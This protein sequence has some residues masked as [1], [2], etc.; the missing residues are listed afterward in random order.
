MTDAELQG[1]A[2][3]AL[4]MARRDLRDPKVEFNFLLGLWFDNG[5]GFYRAK[6]I[7]A[8]VIEKLGKEW[9]SSG[10]AKDFGFDLIRLSVKTMPPEAIV[11]VTA[12]NQF[13][14][15][16]KL[17]ARPEEE[18]RAL[19][20]SSHDRHHEGV[21]QGLYEILD[22]LTAVAQTP[23]RVCMCSVIVGRTDIPPDIRLIEQDD[24]GGRL[25][26][27]GDPNHRPGGKTQ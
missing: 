11:F 15:T 26:M 22:G 27:Y 5:E 17:L 4:N 21:K 8:L 7:E 25:K 12:T 1:F 18:Q 2:N 13:I 24:F 10:A 19:A 3:Q 16:K 23:E 9:L 20:N 6:R 14:P